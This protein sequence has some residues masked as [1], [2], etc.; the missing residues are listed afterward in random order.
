MFGPLIGAPVSP[1]VR[2]DRSDPPAAE[3]TTRITKSG[4]AKS[5][6]GSMAFVLRNH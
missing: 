2:W 5:R 1:K 3:V 4:Q 6:Q